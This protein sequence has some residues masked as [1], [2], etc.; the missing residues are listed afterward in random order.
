MYKLKVFVI[1]A[2]YASVAGSLF[3]HIR[4]FINPSPFNLEFSIL[5]V[6]MVIVGGMRT[7]WGAIIGAC[8][9]GLLPELL[10]E[11][12]IWRFLIYGIILLFIMMFLPQGVLLGIRDLTKEIF[13]RIKRGS[14]EYIL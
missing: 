1:S 10:S 14:E 9:M 6:I 8:L 2:V 4:G 12:E 3:V 13:L 7:V 11:L 5:I